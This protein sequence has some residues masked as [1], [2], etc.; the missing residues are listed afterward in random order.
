[1]LSLATATCWRLKPNRMSDGKFAVSDFDPIR[2]RFPL[3]V[4]QLRP[5]SC[6]PN[7][8]LM[9]PRSPT[10]PSSGAAN[11][12][13]SGK[14][15]LFLCSFNLSVNTEKSDN[16]VLFPVRTVFSLRNHCRNSREGTARIQIRKL[17]GF[18][19]FH[20]G[21][22]LLPFL[23]LKQYTRLSFSRPLVLTMT[24]LV[25]HVLVV[26]W[27]HSPRLDTRQWC[28]MQNKGNKFE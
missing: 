11:A 13:K 7:T 27:L 21:F 18:K 20:G 14:W 22:F 12:G 17:G 23:S 1:M 10:S 3:F 24:S 16:A 26:S 9:Q 2:L 19:C 15:L 8:G 4:D 25:G 28:Y 6:R 5:L